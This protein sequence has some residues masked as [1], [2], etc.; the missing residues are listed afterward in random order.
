MWLSWWLLWP[1]IT[2]WS[3]LL[4]VSGSGSANAQLPGCFR[5]RT[6]SLNI[7]LNMFPLDSFMSCL[8]YLLR[9]ST[10][11]FQALQLNVLA[12]FGAQRQ[13]KTAPKEIVTFRRSMA[14]RIWMNIYDGNYGLHDQV[15]QVYNAHIEIEL[16]EM[17]S[18]YGKR[19]GIYVY[20]HASSSTIKI[21]CIKEALLIN[22]IWLKTMI[23]YI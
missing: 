3:T 4:Y 8:R 16:P 9:Y 2:F 23:Q 22:I 5:P 13:Y 11:K 18:L 12:A 15:N 20:K 1:L 17:L 10:G 14:Y 19:N 6:F 7:G 21:H